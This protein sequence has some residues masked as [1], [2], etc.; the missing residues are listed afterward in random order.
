M[1][2]FKRVVIFEDIH[3]QNHL[4]TVPG[5][6]APLPEIPERVKVIGEALR[7]AEFSYLLKFVS[8]EPAT[9]A[10][11]LLLHKPKHIYNIVNTVAK[12]KEDETMKFVDRNPDVVVTEG[13]D[14]AARYAAGAVRDAVK[15]VLSGAETKVF[16]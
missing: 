10:E 13:S 3:C 6:K 1:E 11:L 16:C 8:P 15:T 4:P 12:A 7:N 5:Q 2:N 14:I 9:D